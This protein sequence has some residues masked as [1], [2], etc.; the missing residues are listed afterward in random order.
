MTT[1][2]PISLSENAAMGTGLCFAPAMVGPR[3]WSLREEA[4]MDAAT[5]SAFMNQSSARTAA[6][7]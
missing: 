6:E 1:I 4:M 5:C 7:C 2:Y 3:C